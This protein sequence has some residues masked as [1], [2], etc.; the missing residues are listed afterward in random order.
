MDLENYGPGRPP[1]DETLALMKKMIKV[2]EKEPGIPSAKLARKVGT[3]SL[4]CAV[5]G[6][7]LARRGHIRIEHHNRALTYFPG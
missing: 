6:R 7:R 2:I 3:N 1:H 4:R 5:L